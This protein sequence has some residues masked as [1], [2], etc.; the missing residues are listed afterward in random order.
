[1]REGGEKAEKEVLVTGVWRNEEESEGKIGLSA[2][3]E[4]GRSARRWE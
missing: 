4:G 2:G 1:V 3:V